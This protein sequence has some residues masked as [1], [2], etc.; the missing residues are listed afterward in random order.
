MALS[1]ISSQSNSGSSGGGGTINVTKPTGLSVGHL[2]FAL[3]DHSNLSF[4]AGFTAIV[5]D[6]TTVS[7]YTAYKIADASDVAASQFSFTAGSAYDGNC[8]IAVFSGVRNSSLFT[9]GTANVVSNTASPTFSNGV[10]PAAENSILLMCIG[11]QENTNLD[12]GNYAITTSNPSSWTEIKEDN[13]SDKVLILA[14]SSIRPQTTATGSYSANGGT[15]TSDY[16][17]YLIALEAPLTTVVTESITITE[18]IGLSTG[19]KSSDSVTLAET[20]SVEEQE[21]TNQTKN[22]GA[23]TNQ[24]KS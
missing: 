16:R 21:W 2:M 5:G 18:N 1:F 20:M 4:P 24:N 19:I 11:S 15:G 14:Y 23:W 9:T 22:T 12:M 13:A 17:S 10:T 3:H 7:L 8:I 6:F